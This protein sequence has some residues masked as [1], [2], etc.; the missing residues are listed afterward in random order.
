MEF[1][2]FTLAGPHLTPG[3]I[4]PIRLDYGSDATASFGLVMTP[5]EREAAE[6]RLTVYPDMH[7]YFAHGKRSTYMLILYGKRIEEAAQEVF[8]AIDDFPRHGDLLL[9]GISQVYNKLL[10]PILLP[11]EPNARIPG[12]LAEFIGELMYPLSQRAMYIVAGI[13]LPDR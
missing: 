5:H 13:A 8:Q 7:G 12:S 10:L 9:G 6:S 1:T 11:E 4:G 3:T 2:S